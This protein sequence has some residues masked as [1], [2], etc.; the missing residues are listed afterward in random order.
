M[1]GDNVQSL[2]AKAQNRVGLKHI[3]SKAYDTN[4]H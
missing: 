2:V 1:D 3:L 4:G